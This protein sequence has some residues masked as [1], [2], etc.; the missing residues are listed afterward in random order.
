MLY[1]A[2]LLSIFAATSVQ[3]APAIS[4]LVRTYAPTSSSTA[5]SRL[6]HKYAPTSPSS[7]AVATSTQWYPAPVTTPPT[8]TSSSPVITRGPAACASY[9]GGN[10]LEGVAWG[11]VYCHDHPG[12]CPGGTTYTTSTATRSRITASP[13]PDPSTI[14]TVPAKVVFST[15]EKA[16]A[17][18]GEWPYQELSHIPCPLASIGTTKDDIESAAWISRDAVR[19]RPVS[20]APAAS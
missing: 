9:V 5:T 3:A 20:P 2:A 13:N 16:G 11:A 18:E 6:V 14:A 17:A 7:S 12:C 15:T 1:A 19:L 8:T 10:P 4:R